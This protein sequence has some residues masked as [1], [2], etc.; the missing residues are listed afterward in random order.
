MFTAPPMRPP[1]GNSFT[2]APPPPEAPPPDD[3]IIDEDIYDAPSD[4]MEET[5]F[6]APP[7]LTNEIP[8]ARPPKVR[9]AFIH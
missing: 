8:P 5:G 7:P 6:R 4:M 9:G 3:E 1:I 2:T